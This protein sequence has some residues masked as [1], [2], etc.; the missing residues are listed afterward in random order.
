MKYLK[1]YENFENDFEDDFEETWI[2]EPD[3][4]LDYKFI[5]IENDVYL[6]EKYINETNSILYEN[7]NWFV[8]TR[9]KILISQSITGTNNVVNDIITN[10]KSFYIYIDNI[11]DWEKIYFEDLPK[12][13]QFKVLNSYNI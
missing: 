12:N 2:D 13:I 10:K 1:L 3:D 6:I 8:F 7:Y 11:D 4:N 9:D 5:N